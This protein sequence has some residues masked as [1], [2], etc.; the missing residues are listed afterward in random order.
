MP[1]GGG[2]GLHAG[3]LMQEVGLK[4]ALVPPYP[5]VTS[6]L[7]CVIADMRHDF[8]QTVNRT[9]EEIDFAAVDAEIARLV[10]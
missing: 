1:F 9:L 8:V 2:G 10:E 3:A 4:A 6:A 5:G 7:G